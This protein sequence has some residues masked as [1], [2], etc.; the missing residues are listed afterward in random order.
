MGQVLAKAD[1][2]HGEIL[3]GNHKVV[4]RFR[5]KTELSKDRYISL[6]Y[7]DAIFVMQLNS[8]VIFTYLLS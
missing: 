4:E 3:R 8:C 6:Y 5:V 2:R 7:Q 1:L